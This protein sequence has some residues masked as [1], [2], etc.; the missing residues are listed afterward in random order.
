MA[1]IQLDATLVTCQAEITAKVG[2]LLLVY[3]DHCLGVYHGV[4]KWPADVS[5]API[6]GWAKPF[7]DF[8]DHDVLAALKSGPKN[9][10]QIGD[11]MRLPRNDTRSRA[12][13]SHYVRQP[14]GRGVIR[15]RPGTV[16]NHVY[17]LAPAP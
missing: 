14:A 13:V 5:K 15:P 9:S 10:M 11:H 17:E 3:G 16:R 4:T 2:D 6:N 12:H 1:I 8:T 7:T